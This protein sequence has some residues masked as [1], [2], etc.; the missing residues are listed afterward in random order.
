MRL[1]REPE[2]TGVV[3]G[4]GRALITGGDG[5][6]YPPQ[7]RIQHQFLEHRLLKGRPRSVAVGGADQIDRGVVDQRRIH[8]IEAT[9][10][11]QR[12]GNGEIS[13]RSH[14]TQH[15]Q[16]KPELSTR[17]VP[18]GGRLADL[19]HG[20]QLPQLHALAAQIAV[21]AVVLIQRIGIH[22][23]GHQAN[24]NP[25]AGAFLLGQAIHRRQLPRVKH[26][27]IGQGLQIVHT[28]AGGISR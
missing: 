26:L 28:A 27:R 8:P 19:T 1:W 2:R 22:H 11:I 4:V 21:E 5:H 6:G 17:S 7:R 12:A 15:A 18:E 24:V 16:I 9:E 10:V 3:L 25:C 23:A 20:T 14:R 13:G